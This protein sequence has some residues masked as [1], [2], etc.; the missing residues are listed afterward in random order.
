[1]KF[2]TT[3]TI[4]LLIPTMS[5]SIQA[6]EVKL[7][8]ADHQNVFGTFTAAKANNDKIVLLFHQARSNRHE[9]DTVAPVINKAGFDTL[10]IDQ[11][12]GGPMWGEENQTV[13]AAGKSTEYA[14]A[15]PDLQAAVD[16]AVSKK[17][18]KIITVGSSYTA[19]LNFHLAK[20]N[21][22]HITAMASFSPG[23]YLGKNLSVAEAAR[24]L[25]LP[26]YVTS[27]SQSDELKRA[28][29]ILKN[30][31]IKQLTRHRPQAGVHGASTL[32]KDRNPKGCQENLA[33]FMA[34]LES[35]K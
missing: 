4:C 8:T 10:R 20:R 15:Y 11:R 16:W 34:F 17:Y 19:A 25:K 14:E 31:N 18:K 27:G 32:R 13:K 30:A 26:V 35:V 28:D 24:G 7:T 5:Q 9:Y 29:D 6:E 23:E 21:S 2:L 3:L 22:D 12:S 1:M 33:D